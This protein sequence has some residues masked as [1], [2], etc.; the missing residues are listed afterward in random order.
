VEAADL[1]ARFTAGRSFEDYL[2]D[3]ML[4]AAVERK[5]EVIGEALTQ[6]AKRDPARASEISEYRQIIAFRNILAH[7]YAD[8][9]DRLVWDIVHSKLAVLRGDAALL[10]GVV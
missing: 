6:L 10:L 7:G 5:F 2:T 9:D 3:P 8:V 4:R 1:I